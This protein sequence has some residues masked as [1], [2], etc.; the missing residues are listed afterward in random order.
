MNYILIYSVKAKIQKVII[1][2]YVPFDLLIWLFLIWI[3]KRIMRYKHKTEH[4]K[5]KNS[6]KDGQ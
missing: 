6:L 3:T 5:Q 1:L 2:F 4:K